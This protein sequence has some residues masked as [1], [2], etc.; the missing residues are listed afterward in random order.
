[1]KNTAAGHAEVEQA[2]HCGCP[3]RNMKKCPPFMPNG[4]RFYMLYYL[5]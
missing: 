5:S 4:G 3:G 1:M 2:A